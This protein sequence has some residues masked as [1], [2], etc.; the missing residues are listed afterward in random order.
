VREIR[1]ILYLLAAAVIFYWRWGVWVPRKVGRSCRRGR[2]SPL[3]RF[4]KRLAFNLLSPL[5]L[6]SRRCLKRTR[7]TGRVIF[8]INPNGT[9]KSF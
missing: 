2:R 6:L 3:G 1:Y 9:I 8:Q 7:R 4:G 5:G